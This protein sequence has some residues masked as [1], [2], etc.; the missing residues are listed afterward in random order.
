MGFSYDTCITEQELSKL[1]PIQRDQMILRSCI[2]D[3]IVSLQWKSMPFYEAKDT[4]SNFGMENFKQ[5]ISHLRTDTLALLQHSHNQLQGTITLQKPKILYF[6]I[7]YDKGWKA[8]V[9]GKEMP[10]ERV[11]IGFTGLLLEQGQHTIQLQFTPPLLKEGAMISALG[12]VLYGGVV[13]WSWRRNRSGKSN[14]PLS[15]PESDREA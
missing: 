10:L 11:N 1:L 5:S 3:S 2:I 6:S 8:T 15:P 14:E 12:L 9:D 4:I 13:V 7:P